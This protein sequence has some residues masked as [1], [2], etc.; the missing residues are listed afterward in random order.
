MTRWPSVTAAASG[1]I[2]RAKQYLTKCSKMMM[3][4]GPAKHAKDKNRQFISCVYVS[5]SSTCRSSVQSRP[6]L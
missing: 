6:C 1:T 2:A 4:T 5:E 3:H